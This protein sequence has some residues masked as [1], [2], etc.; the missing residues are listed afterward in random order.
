MCI[1][2]KNSAFEIGKN[3]AALINATSNV[4]RTS[5]RDREIGEKLIVF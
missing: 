2:A 3:T 1:N 4:E 5:E